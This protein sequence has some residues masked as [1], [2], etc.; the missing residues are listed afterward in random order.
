[1]IKSLRT[2]R[3][4]GGVSERRK[5]KE[6]KAHTHRHADAPHLVDEKDIVTAPKTPSTH[7]P[8]AATNIRLR[9]VPEKPAAVMER[10]R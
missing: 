5:G 6:G 3:L 2:S 7:S 9:Q 1:M 10:E 8:I 4:K